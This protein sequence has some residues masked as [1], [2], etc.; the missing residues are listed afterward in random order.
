MTPNQKRL[1]KDNVLQGTL[2]TAL[3]NRKLWD[4]IVLLLAL[5]SNNPIKGALEEIT[6]K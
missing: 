4:C 5:P 1:K 2:M 3:K 6:E